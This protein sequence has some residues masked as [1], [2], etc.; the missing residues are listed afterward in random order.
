MA[1]SEIQC[2]GANFGVMY[3]SVHKEFALGQHIK[4]LEIW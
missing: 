4:F 3:S 1:K 2:F